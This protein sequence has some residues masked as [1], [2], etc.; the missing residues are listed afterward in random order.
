MPYFIKKYNAEVLGT[1][2]GKNGEIICL[3]K[4]CIFKGLEGSTIIHFCSK[5]PFFLPCV[6][7][8]GSA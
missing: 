3:F 8:S 7:D 5:F 4:K 2:L 6:I 1:F